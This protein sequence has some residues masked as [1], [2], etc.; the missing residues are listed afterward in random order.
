V[1]A[2]ADQK[3]KLQQRKLLQDAGNVNAKFAFG[4]PTGFQPFISESASCAQ[5]AWW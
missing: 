1:L 2:V 4:S 3:I 5:P